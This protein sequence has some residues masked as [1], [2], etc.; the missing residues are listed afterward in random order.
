MTNQT[1]TG[2]DSAG[3]T[4]AA[5]AALSPKQIQPQAYTACLTPPARPPKK[6]CGEKT[7]KLW[8][9]RAT[10][11]E[12]VLENTYDLRSNRPE[13]A[14]LS[15]PYSVSSFGQDGVNGNATRTARSS[16]F[17]ILPTPCVKT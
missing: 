4:A 14:V 13:S 12:V 1:T 15:C 11:K 17:N 7:N 10:S 5:A 6:W 2:I 8:H 3:M 9:T 16:V